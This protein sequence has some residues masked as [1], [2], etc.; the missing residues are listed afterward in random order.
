MYCDWQGAVAIGSWGPGWVQRQVCDLL[1][2][3]FLL[4]GLRASLE[5]KRWRG[6]L[7]CTVAACK[8]A[9]LVR[10][11]VA[12]QLSSH[13]PASLRAARLAGPAPRPLQ[14]R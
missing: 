14:A 4:R 5:L 9:R 7:A 3:C 13:A 1:S 12:R 10:L 8:G 2:A 6:V 11:I